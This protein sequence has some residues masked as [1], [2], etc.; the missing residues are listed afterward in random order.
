MEML[1]TAYYMLDERERSP[2]VLMEAFDFEV[3]CDLTEDSAC[4]IREGIGSWLTWNEMNRLS[5]EV[6]LECMLAKEQ[7][8]RFSTEEQRKSRR[9]RPSEIHR[10]SQYLDEWEK[11]ERSSNK[12]KQAAFARE[13]GITP[14]AM[15]RA[16]AR[17]RKDRA[18]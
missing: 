6:R 9:G 16:L 18:R 10:D 14:S 17:A 5:A 2:R 13:K 15:S 12:P 3:P 4:R 11:R 7:N 1:E 8:P